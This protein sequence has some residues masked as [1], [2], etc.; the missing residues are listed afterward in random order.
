MDKIWH[1]TFCNEPLVA[2]EAS[3]LPIC[4]SSAWSTGNI[5]LSC[6]SFF[7][8]IYPNPSRTTMTLSRNLWC[9]EKELYR[10]R[11]VDY[12]YV[13]NMEECNLL[14]RET[15]TDYVSAIPCQLP[16]LASDLW[17]SETLSIK[18]TP[19]QA[20]ENWETLT[21]DVPRSTVFD[22]ENIPGS[23]TARSRPD[24]RN[25]PEF[26]WIGGLGVYRT[27]RGIHEISMKYIA[28]IKQV[29]L[30][31]ITS[32]EKRAVATSAGFF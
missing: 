3:W 16:A 30:E 23:R 14:C 19:I 15:L 13:Q 2:P 31:K 22:A 32:D 24:F 7:I 11:L 27:I 4:V 8:I 6:P 20:T 9:H 28:H 21:G 17:E 18:I 26:L 29:S 10:C 25:M 1:H 12:H 5:P